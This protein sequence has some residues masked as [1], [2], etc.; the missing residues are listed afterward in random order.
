M[1]GGGGGGGHTGGGGGGRDGW[2]SQARRAR[3]RR[4][5]WRSS[6]R[7]Y[8]SGIRWRGRRPTGRCRYSGDRKYTA[9]WRRPP[10]RPLIPTG[11]PGTGRRPRQARVRMWGRGWGGPR[12]G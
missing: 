6:A 9:P 4:R 10:I 3:R 5:G 11:G 8:G 2:E 1:A 7:G 12:G